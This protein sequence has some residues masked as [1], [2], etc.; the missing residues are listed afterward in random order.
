MLGG[1]NGIYFDGDAPVGVDLD[2]DWLEGDVDASQNLWQNRFMSVMQSD[3][4]NMQFML[5]NVLRAVS[6]A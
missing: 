4:L 1:S 2:P 6:R 5:Q 3:K